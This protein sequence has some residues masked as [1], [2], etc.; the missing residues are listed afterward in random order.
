MVLCCELKRT[1]LEEQPVFLTTRS[2]LIPIP[3]IIKEAELQMIQPHY[4]QKETCLF[5]ILNQEV[6]GFSLT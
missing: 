6:G 4:R 3:R 2:S 5:D 1:P